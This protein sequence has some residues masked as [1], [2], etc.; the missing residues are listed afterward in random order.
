LAELYQQQGKYEQAKALYQRA[1]SIREQ[2]LG[3]EHPDTASS[4]HGLAELYQQQ[5]KYEQAKA[6][7]QRALHI[8]EQCLGPDHPETEKTRLAYAA[9]ERNERTYSS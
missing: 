6:L 8:R 7:Y 4:L 5:G 9:G 3:P 2:H 1:L